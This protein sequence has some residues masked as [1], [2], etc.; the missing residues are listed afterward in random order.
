MEKWRNGEISREISQGRRK[1]RKKDK[2]RKET[3]SNTPGHCHT[4]RQVVGIPS[5]APAILVLD[6]SA[7][8]LPLEWGTTTT[9]CR[10]RGFYGSTKYCTVHPVMLYW[11]QYQSAYCL[12]MAIECLFEFNTG[13]IAHCPGTE[14]LIQLVQAHQNKGYWHRSHSVSGL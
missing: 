11:L 13:D 12:A 5:L 6:E 4:C 1:E 3:A 14:F 9:I 8:A 7:R 2:K 10:A